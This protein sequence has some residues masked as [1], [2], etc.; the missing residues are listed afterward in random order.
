MFHSKAPRLY[1][2]GLRTRPQVKADF[3]FG[4]FMRHGDIV[5][6]IFTSDT[7]SDS[8]KKPKK[9]HFSGWLCLQHRYQSVEDAF[10]LFT[11]CMCP[12][13][14]VCCASI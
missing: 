6:D 4:I 3:Y 12:S 7:T 14:A 8:S 9:F 5:T 2:A 11:T 1:E 10:C 13:V